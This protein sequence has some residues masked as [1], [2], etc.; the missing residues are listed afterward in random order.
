MLTGCCRT[1]LLDLFKHIGQLVS[2]ED[3]DN[4]RRCFVRTKTMI[5][6]RVSDNGSQQLAVLVNGTDHSRTEHEEL[7]VFVRCLT[8]IKQIPLGGIP[9]RPVAVFTRPINAGKRFFVQQALHPVLCRHL[10]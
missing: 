1:A 5:I 3:R 4:R 7:H 10:L 8:G 9:Q 6:A 2:E